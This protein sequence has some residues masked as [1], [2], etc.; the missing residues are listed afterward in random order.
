MQIFV[1]FE[2]V[3]DSF[4]AFVRT[5]IRFLFNFKC[6]H[7]PKGN[8][9]AHICLSER[10]LEVVRRLPTSSSRLIHGA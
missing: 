2:H 1:G 7:G 5:E 3:R 8:A 4:K 6:R 10:D 9:F